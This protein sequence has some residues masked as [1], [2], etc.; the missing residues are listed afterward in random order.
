MK[1]SPK[2]ENIFGS[3]E[4]VVEGNVEDLEETKIIKLSK[5]CVTRWTVRALCFNRIIEKYGT[6]QVLW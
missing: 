4:E 3:I 1:L 2:R 6:L 5:L